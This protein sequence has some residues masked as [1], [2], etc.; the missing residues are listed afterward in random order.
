VLSTLNNL[1][2][3]PP[4][5]VSLWAAT[6]FICYLDIL[7]YIIFYTDKHIYYYECYFYFKSLFYCTIFY[8]MSNN[9]YNLDVHISVTLSSC[10]C[11]MLIAL[12]L[13]Y[14]SRVTLFYSLI[15]YLYRILGNTQHLVYFVQLTLT[16][17]N[18]FTI[19][20]LY[21]RSFFPQLYFSH[22]IS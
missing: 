2:I 11:I 19:F 8:V 6:W 14:T 22:I 1:C 10:N 20:L 15:N 3:R 5:Q 13:I 12:K 4:P 9:M 18:Y 21:H 7:G 17:Y 16:A